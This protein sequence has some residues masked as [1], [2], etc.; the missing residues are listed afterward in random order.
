MPSLAPEA[1][2]RVRP[3]HL[4]ANLSAQPEQGVQRVATDQEP[5]SRCALA[6]S[7]R[8]VAIQRQGGADVHVFAAQDASQA[9]VRPSHTLRAGPNSGALTSH[10]MGAA[11][12]RPDEILL[13]FETYGK[14]NLNLSQ[15]QIYHSA[16][17]VLAETGR[18]RP[19]VIPHANYDRRR[20]GQRHLSAENAAPVP[21]TFFKIES[22][23]VRCT[24]C[25]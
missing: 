12:T 10:D 9:E 2:V 25:T 15:K 23:V 16:D 21:L 13:R 18:A 20:F 17:G 22:A 24:A 11:P 6:E 5:C 7:A 14:T 8:V 1:V 3:R 4:V 19:A